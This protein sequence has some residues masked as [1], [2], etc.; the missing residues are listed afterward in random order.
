[1]RV[2]AYEW[3]WTHHD[4]L[5]HHHR[6]YTRPRAVAAVEAAVSRCVRATYAFAGTFPFFAA[7]RLRPAPRA[8]PRS[9]GTEEDGSRRCPRSARPSSG[10]CSS[11]GRLD[12]AAA[13]QCDL[14][15]GSSVLVPRASRRLGCRVSGADHEHQISVVIPVYQGRRRSPACSARSSAGS[16]P[17]VT[18]G[19]HRAR[20][21]EVVLVHDCGP[22]ASDEV[23]REAGARPTTGSARCG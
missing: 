12:R 4:V 22:D 23:I 10:S 19:G 16:D 21:T 5:N 17:F 14:P 3:A 8:G 2:P 18:A 11:G 15:F 1:M 6:R 13:P 9:A 20:V 7:D